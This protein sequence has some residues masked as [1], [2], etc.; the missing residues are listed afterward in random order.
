MQKLRTAVITR[1]T[2]WGSDEDCTVPDVAD[3]LNTWKPGG[4]TEIAAAFTA[5][6]QRLKDM[7]QAWH[8]VKCQAVP[9]VPHGASTGAPVVLSCLDLGFQ[10]SDSV[11]GKSKMVNV[12]EVAFSYMDTRRF[13]SMRLPLSVFFADPPGTKLTP[14]CTKHIV[15][16][17]RSLA[18]KMLVMEACILEPTLTDEEMGELGSLLQSCFE[19]HAVVM[20][21]AGGKDIGYA[22]MRN[23]FQVSESVR[24]DVLQLYH[25]LSGIVAQPTQQELKQAIAEF[26]RSSSVAGQRISDLE[27]KVVTFLPE[28]T[29]EFGRKLEQHW[30]NYKVAESAVPMKFFTLLFSGPGDKVAE[31]RSE[32]WARIFCGSAF[33]N[34]MALTYAIGIFHKNLKDNSR[35]LKKKVNLKVQSSKFRIQDPVL[36][37]KLSCV[38]VE[39]RQEWAKMLDGKQ[40]AVV[41]KMFL[42]GALDR[43]LGDALKVQDAELKANSFSFL[44]SVTGQ[45]SDTQKLEQSI[46]QAEMSSETAQ[47]GLFTARLQ[48]EQQLFLA[49]KKAVNDYESLQKNGRQ[50]HVAM[51]E[52]KMTSL[53]EARLESRYPMKVVQE[54]H[55][56]PWFG[57]CIAGLSDTLALNADNAYHIFFCNLTHFGSNFNAHVHGM[58]RII[59]D[60]IGCTSALHIAANRSVG[61]VLAP[62]VG[63]PGT[64]QYEDNAIQKAQ[65]QVDELLRDSSNQVRVRRCAIAFAGPLGK[66]SLSHVLWMVISEVT[67]SAETDE[68]ISCFASSALWNGRLINNVTTKAV[69][70]FVIPSMASMKVGGITSFSKA[71]QFKQHIAGPALMS[72]IMDQLWKGVPLGASAVAGWLDL[73]PYDGGL[74]A[75]MSACEHIANV[76]QFLCS[77]YCFENSPLTLS[78]MALWQQDFGLRFLTA[79][80][81]AREW[82]E[83]APDGSPPVFNSQD[84][85]LTK[86]VPSDGVLSL[87]LRQDVLS[88]KE[89]CSTRLA[90]EFTKIINEHNK[91]YNVSGVPWRGDHAPP[92]RSSADETQAEPFP[93]EHAVTEESLK[94]KGSPLVTVQSRV[95]SVQLLLKTVDGTKQV[96]LKSLSDG[97][98]SKEEPIFHVYGD[99]V[100]GKE[101]AE[102]EKSKKVLW[103][104]KMESMDYC[105]SIASPFEDGFKCNLTTLQKFFDFLVTKNKGVPKIVCHEVKDGVIKST[106]ACAYQPKPLPAKTVESKENIGSLL[107]F[108]DTDW[109]TGSH[110]FG[111]LELKCHLKYEDSPQRSG[112]FPAKP[113]YHLKK[114]YRFSK[115]KVYR[116][117]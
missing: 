6:E 18:A 59:V 86:M 105:L 40:L 37:L 33:K 79:A 11:R 54:C 13:D 69:A 45:V 28:Q 7:D 4:A 14:F 92:A 104:W 44:Q 61:L 36:G 15:G 26:N 84:L 70:D 64:G 96:Y 12:L 27:S 25:V 21:P 99:Y 82:R 1:Y 116:I 48:R 17:G 81:R 91:T 55:V 78:E 115:E 87:P 22:S 47:F 32:L 9:A 62:N 63:V 101:L 114:T 67:K 106:E 66:R 113:A 111:F 34:E 103:P 112:L 102:L 8:P 60:G 5:L 95:S 46:A 23:K 75:A 35:H 65:D 20:G 89:R 19:I 43:E 108:A 29:S 68:P 97:T 51:Q 41:D 31:A 76:S 90:D 98:V 30:Q 58:A 88:E 52:Q 110:K 80:V 85:V 24:P 74:L 117:A 93:E 16:F 10:E 57:T 49:H 94:T 39:F 77:A 2:P 38:F 83:Y 107:P 50:S 73:C 42:R 109:S 53:A 56:Y 72:G 100:T 3:V 71:Q